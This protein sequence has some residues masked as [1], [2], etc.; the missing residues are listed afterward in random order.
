MIRGKPSSRV[1]LGRADTRGGDDAVGVGGCVCVCVCGG[2]GVDSGYAVDALHALHSTPQLGRAVDARGRSAQ[3]GGGR[4]SVCTATTTARQ[5][6]RAC[7]TTSMWWSGP[8]LA[9][10][11]PRVPESINDGTTH[12]YDD[13]QMPARARTRLFLRPGCFELSLAS[14]TAPDRRQGAFACTYAGPGQGARE[15]DRVR[16]RRQGARFCCDQSRHRKREQR[17]PTD[18]LAKHGLARRG[19]WRRL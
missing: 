19:V 14:Y 10:V 2:G 11:A 12:A 4:R 15:G 6:G 18:A 3:L 16:R 8:A 9:P 1:D 17:N 13:V 5:M 7:A